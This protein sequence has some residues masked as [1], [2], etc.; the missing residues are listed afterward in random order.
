MY[1]FFFALLRTFQDAIR[2]LSIRSEH[3]RI[4]I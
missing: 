3:S 1:I 2:M 4:S